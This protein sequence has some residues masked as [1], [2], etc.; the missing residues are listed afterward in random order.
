MNLMH[1]EKAWILIILGAVFLSTAILFQSRDIGSCPNFVTGEPATCNTYFPGT[2]IVIAPTVRFL[3][4][5]S[6]PFLGAGVFLMLR[7]YDRKNHA[8]FSTREN[9]PNQQ[10]LKEGERDH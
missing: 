4:I 10:A 1:L 6:I 5:V 7:D 8:F 9:E 2:N 3:V